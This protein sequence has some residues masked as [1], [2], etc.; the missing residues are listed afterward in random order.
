MLV[1]VLRCWNDVV[2]DNSRLNRTSRVR[3]R[4][5]LVTITSLSRESD[6]LGESSMFN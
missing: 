3:L 4:T 6:D 1:P 5:N 2:C